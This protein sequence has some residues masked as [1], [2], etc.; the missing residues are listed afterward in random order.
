[1]YTSI[2]STFIT[3]NWECTLWRCSPSEAPTIF[4]THPPLLCGACKHVLLLS[5]FPVVGSLASNWCGQW[6]I[7]DVGDGVWLWHDWN[8]NFSRWSPLSLVS[9]ALLYPIVVSPNLLVSCILGRWG[10]WRWSYH[11]ITGSITMSLFN[12][13]C[14]SFL[15]LEFSCCGPSVCSQESAS[16]IV[17]VVISLLWVC[18]ISMWYVYVAYVIVGIF[19]ICRAL[20]AKGH[21][22]L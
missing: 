11:S 10:W 5:I 12:I 20:W 4:L 15:F 19:L 22:I 2:Y 14:L 17:L 8:C 16:V 18:A 7:P 9:E 21:S 13:L 3:S 6:L 1:M